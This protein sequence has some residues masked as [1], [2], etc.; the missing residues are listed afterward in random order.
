MSLVAR[1][2]F[3]IDNCHRCM[4]VMRTLTAKYAGGYDD[5][6]RQ[7]GEEPVGKLAS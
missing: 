6:A 7:M 1:L 5:W 2:S 4:D 3:R